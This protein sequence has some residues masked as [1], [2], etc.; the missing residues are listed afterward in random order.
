MLAFSSV[1]AVAASAES[2]DVS[3]MNPLDSFDLVR[4]KSAEPS[5]TCWA[6]GA[7]EFIEGSARSGGGLVL[8][9]EFGEREPYDRFGKIHLYKFSGSVSLTY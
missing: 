7:N 5:V 6:E 4:A 2:S 3:F 8:S 1:L 9:E